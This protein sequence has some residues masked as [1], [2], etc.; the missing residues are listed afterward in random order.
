MAILE[1]RG[2]CLPEREARSLWIDGDTIRT[3]PVAGA[4]VV[5]DRGWLL[6]GLVD[7]HTHPGTEDPKDP[8]DE[9]QL[10]RHLTAHR[11]AGVLLVRTPGTAARIPAWVDD[12]PELPRVRSGGRWLATP[13]RFFPGYGRDIAESELVAAC[14]EEAAA[15]SGWC[16]II[17]DWMH[18]GVPVPLDLLT[19]ATT[20]VHAAGGKVAAHCQTADGCRNAVLAGVDSVEHGMHLDPELLDRMAAQRTALVPTLGAF[21]DHAE[22]VQAFEPSARR[23]WWLAGWDGMPHTVRAAHEAGVRIFAGTDTVPFGTVA[24]EIQWLVRAGLPVERAIA[25]GS[26]DARSWLGLP[27]LVD[28]APADI[29]VF[30]TDPTRDAAVLAHPH[31][32]ILRGR[33]VR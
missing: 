27:G 28:G 18:D 26:W 24:N 19:A 14:V 16:K 5:V 2:V 1:V 29:V 33:I 30:D 21:G 25:A 31:R 7:V 15:S 10:R 17:T 3:E 9:E 13:G 4:D 22:T 20:A 32:I 8:F 12:D 11:D 23:D 6:P